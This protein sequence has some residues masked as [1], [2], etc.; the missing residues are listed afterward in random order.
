MKTVPTEG[1]VVKYPSY[2]FENILFL[3]LFFVFIC[4]ECFEKIY[5][6]YSDPWNISEGPS[7]P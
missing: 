6:L 1:Q 4:T 5:L 2:L 7:I 3:S